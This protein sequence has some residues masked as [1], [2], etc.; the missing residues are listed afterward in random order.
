MTW[1]N[2]RNKKKC[3]N[4]RF[5]L[6]CFQ[7]EKKNIKRKPRVEQSQSKMLKENIF[8]NKYTKIHASAVQSTVMYDLAHVSDA[9]CTMHTKP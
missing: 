3:D 7:K 8:V 5:V 6:A 2:A 4:R 1:S 9:M